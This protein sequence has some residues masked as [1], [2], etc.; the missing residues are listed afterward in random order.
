V[1]GQAR[2]GSQRLKSMVRRHIIHYTTLAQSVDAQ[3]REFSKC[4]RTK[5]T[6]KHGCG[7]SYQSYF[8]LSEIRVCEFS[9]YR[10][11]DVPEP[12]RHDGLRLDEAED[13]LN[14]WK[15]RGPHGG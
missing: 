12:I 5:L 15:L 1:A 10:D 14:T 4:K 3:P 6:G 9:L 11:V 7:R 13:I 2:V 8:S